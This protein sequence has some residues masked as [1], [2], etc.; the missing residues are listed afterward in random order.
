MS[1]SKRYNEKVDIGMDM[2]EKEDVGNRKKAVHEPHS[3]KSPKRKKGKVEHG[4]ANIKKM[5]GKVRKVSQEQPVGIRRLATRMTPRRVSASVKLMSLTQIYGILSMGFVSLMNID[6]DT[7]PRLLNYYLLDHYDPQSNRLV[8]KNNVITITKKTVHNMLGLPNDGKDFL[9][10]DSYE[11]DNLVYVYN[12]NFSGVKVMKSLPFVK[13]VTGDVL[14]KIEKLEISVGG[15]GRQLHK[16]FENVEVDDEMMDEA[17]MLDGLK[18]DYGDE[19]AYVAVI[20]HSYG[21]ILSEKKNIQMTLKDGMEKLRNSLMLKECNKGEADGS[22]EGGISL[23]RG[24]VVY[25]GKKNDGGDFKA[26]ATHD[27]WVWNAFFGPTSANNN[28][29]VLDQSPVFNDIY[30]GKSHDKPF[31]A[32]VAYKRGY[33]STDDIY[34]PLSVF[35]KSFTYPNDPKRKKFKEAQESARK[36]VERKFGVLKRRWQVLG[37]GA[38]LYEVKRLQHVMYACVILH[39]MILEDEGRTICRYKGNEFL[40]NLEGVAI[41]TQEY[42][43]NRREVH[44]YDTRH[45]LCADLVAHVYMTHI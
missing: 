28:I 40:S 41:G 8:L 30:F 7:T 39:N 20:E 45:A 19:E 37:V 10:M 38:R 21:I 35:V 29:N 12:T 23:V 24:L 2:E 34:P 6:M 14:Q 1:G 15:F 11:K 18:N 32:K 5:E 4:N 9:N 22:N 31:Q 36:D 25:V 16:N 3:T 43:A 33:Y 13:H 26:I 42:R 17:E 44:N 27:L